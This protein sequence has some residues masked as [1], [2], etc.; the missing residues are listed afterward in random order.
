MF[1]DCLHVKSLLFALRPPAQAQPTAAAARPQRAS[2]APCQQ[3]RQSLPPRPDM[4][5]CAPTPAHPPAT[6]AQPPEGSSSY[7]P[8]I[9]LQG[10][11][12]QRATAC[13]RWH[14][15][16]HD[17]AFRP[18]LQPAWPGA[19]RPAQHKPPC[20]PSCKPAHG[21]ARREFGNSEVRNSELQD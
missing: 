10:L 14:A 6:A 12:W 15:M 2:D 1:L 8:S 17:C 11:I 13:M 9:V 16:A 20:V 19:P 4:Q 21:N 5:P 7:R 18:A 3:A